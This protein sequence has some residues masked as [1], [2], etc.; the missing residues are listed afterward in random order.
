MKLVIDIGNTR[1]KMAVFDG[2]EILDLT[3]AANLQV[4]QIKEITRRF[5]AIRSVILSAVKRYSDAIDLFLDNHFRYIKLNHNT[6]LPFENSYQSPQSLGKDRMAIAAAC[7]MLFP[8]EHVLAI[9]AGTTVTYDFVNRNGEYLGGRISPG[10]SMRLKALHAFT[11][12]LPLVNIDDEIERLPLIG[13]NTT[14]AISSGVLG[15]LI[16][17]AEGVIDQAKHTFD[18]LKVIVGGGDYKYF[19]KRLKNNIFA[20][21]NIVLVGLKEILR[22]N[23]EK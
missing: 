15:G 8:N 3:Y 7:R 13:A 12:R 19:D 4:D 16:S 5:P 23:E 14:Q 17:E 10:L 2:D 21:P 18:G 9:V 1:A 22:F 6:P 11:D 20:A